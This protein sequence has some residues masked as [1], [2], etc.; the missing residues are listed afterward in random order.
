LIGVKKYKI[1]VISVHKF[2]I[3]MIMMKKVSLPEH[4]DDIDLLTNA[5]VE[6]L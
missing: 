6:E 1:Y 4:L 5:H 2:S 3:G